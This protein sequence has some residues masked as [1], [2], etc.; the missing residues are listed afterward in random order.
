MAI[1]NSV[2]VVASGRREHRPQRWLRSPRAL[3]DASTSSRTCAAKQE[4]EVPK[5]RPAQALCSMMV[6]ALDQAIGDAP[7]RRPMTREGCFACSQQVGL[8]GSTKEGCHH[9]TSAEL[10]RP[11][12]L[13]PQTVYSQNCAL[14]PHPRESYRSKLL[15]TFLLAPRNNSSLVKNG[16]NQKAQTIP[17]LCAHT[18][19]HLL[20]CATSAR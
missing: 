20:S 9:H 8:L 12:P 1:S 10:L 16:P 15:S 5:V 19:A 17:S 2:G 11:S 14:S 7:R 3:L 4:L 6:R 13:Y 18:F